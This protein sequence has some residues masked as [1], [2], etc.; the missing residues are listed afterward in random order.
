MNLHL[1][2]P[3]TSA[4]PPGV[5]KSLIFGNLQRYWK[6]NTYITDFIDIAKQF[7]HR[8]IARGYEKET[9][10]KIFKEAAKKLDNFAKATKSTDDTL[11]LHWTWHPRCITKSKLCLLYK[12]LYKSKVVFNN[13]IICYSRPKSLRDSLM[14]TKLNEPEGHRIFHLLLQ[15]N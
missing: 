9:I 8:L 2:I 13:L 10:K 11:Y 6:Q 4:H 3:P 14:Q 5:Q 7:A 12:T 15:K 1:Y